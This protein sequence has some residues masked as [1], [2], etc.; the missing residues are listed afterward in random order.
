MIFVFDLDGTI[1]FNG[2]LLEEHICEALDRCINLGHE[3]VFASAR[4][5]R[6]LLPVLPKKYHSCRMIGGN[7][8]FT[9]L[10]GK[11]TVTYFATDTIKILK[12]MIEKFQL[13][14]LA[15]SDWDYCYTGSVQHPIFK[16]L[17]PSKTAKN[18]ELD[19][20]N[21]ISKLLIFSPPNEVR[22]ALK[23]LPIALFEHHTENVIDI[24]PPGIHKYKG[25]QQLGITEYVAFGNDAND[26][27]LFE[28]ARYS[29]CVGNH[30]VSMHADVSINKD[31]VAEQIMKIAEKDY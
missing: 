4:P 5:I 7:G 16:N 19:Q 17:D 21:G 25:L 31:Q 6:D 9:F 26:L 15:D 27:A 20:L 23:N 3:V 18:K 28:H 24:S 10:N 22:I 30:P 1:C 13:T 29:I 2:Q 14:F 11:V 12:E 8:A